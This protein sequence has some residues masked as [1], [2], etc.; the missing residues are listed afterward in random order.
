MGGEMENGVDAFKGREYGVEV[1]DAGLS[2]GNA[3]DLSPIDGAELVLVAEVLQ[4]QSADQAACTGYEDLIDLHCG[5]CS[6][7]A[8][9][10]R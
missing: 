6:Q 3:L 2:A 7:M 10:A 5:Y 4:D 8:V 1:G 9:Q